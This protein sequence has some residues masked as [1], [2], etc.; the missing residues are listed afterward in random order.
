MPKLI[1]IRHAETNFN[2]EG[3]FSGQADALVT[4]KGLKETREKFADFDKKFDYIYRSSLTRTKQTLEAIIPGAKAI[5]DDRIKE[6]NLGIW[7]E[8]MK[9]ELDQEQLAKFRAGEYTPPGGEKRIDVEKRVIDFVVDMFNKYK[10]N[11]RILVVT[12][13]GVIRIIMSKIL[14]E[15]SKGRT[16]NLCVVEVNDNDFDEFMKNRGEYGSN[17]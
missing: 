13:A 3:R 8:T 2:I 6:A 7:A 17:N 10:G 1:F 11:E 5:I 14:N 4:E 16:E 12:H 15:E 9:N